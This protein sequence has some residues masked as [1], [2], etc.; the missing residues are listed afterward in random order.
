MFN[1]GLIGIL[2][3]W[4]GD[5]SILVEDLLHF[6]WGPCLLIIEKAIYVSSFQFGFLPSG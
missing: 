3:L 6:D 4:L 5:P 1:Q 2:I